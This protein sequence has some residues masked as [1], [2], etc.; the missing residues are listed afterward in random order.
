MPNT[1]DEGISELSILNDVEKIRAL[2][3]DNMYNRIFDLPE[4]MADALKIGKN[5]KINADEFDGAKNI[6]VVGMG[7]SAIAAELA[8]SLFR[9]TLLVPINIC[10]HYELPEYVD[11]ESIVVVSSYSGNT[12]ETLAALDDALR[13]KAM[14]V[15]ISTGGMLQDVAKL[16]EFPIAVIPEGMQPRA[17]IGYSLIPLLFFLE[18][19]GLV[20]NIEK[21]ITEAITK[22][23]KYREGYIEDN[24]VEQ[25][26][27]KKLAEKI[28][29]RIPIIYSGPTLTD[30]VAIRWKGQICENSKNLAFANQFPEF[31]HNELVGWSKTVIP[32]KD[33]LVVI[34]FRDADDHPQIRKRMGI[35]KGIIETHDI[36]V[37]EVHSKGV[38][39][40]ERAFSLIQLGD[41]V[42]YYLAVLQDVDPSPVKVI[43]LL[44]SELAEQK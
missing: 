4:Q 25:N 14:I 27:A 31:N 1:K 33:H 18:K 9:S 39:A 3:P 40:L 43:E 30:A 10:R 23:S 17:A 28:H 8:R 5:W 21:D 15:A 24:L 13:R 36:E 20:K 6:V 35:V 41:F 22:L 2:D 37:I 32:H 12:E 44:K 29:G 42:S 7:G 26:Q 34:L 11:D 19:I 38:P 16:N